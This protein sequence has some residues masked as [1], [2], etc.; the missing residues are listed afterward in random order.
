MSVLNLNSK[1]YDLLKK[2]ASEEVR[3]I[4]DQAA[5]YILLGHLFSENR[6]ISFHELQKKTLEMVGK[7]KITE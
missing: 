7:M 1:I 2:K 4:G 6:D 5:Y 3:K